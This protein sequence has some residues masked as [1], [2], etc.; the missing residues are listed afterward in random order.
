MG[1]ASNRVV[2]NAYNHDEIVPTGF[3]TLTR[4]LEM[5]LGNFRDTL[6]KFTSPKMGNAYNRVGNAYNHDEI[7]PTGFETL[8]RELE[9]LL[10]NFRETL[11]KLT[12]PKMGNASNR[13]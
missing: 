12:S 7:V 6:E 9:M 10:G 13:V 5:L 1:N 4:E 8:T 2:G 11:E 3:E